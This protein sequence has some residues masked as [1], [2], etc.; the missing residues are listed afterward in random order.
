MGS[1]RVR[2]I[3]V[4]V[5]EVVAYVLLMVGAIIT[6]ASGVSGAVNSWEAEHGGETG[7][8]TP[9]EQHCSRHRVTTVVCTWNGTWVSDVD[10]RILRDVHLDDSL[11]SEEGDAPPEPVHPALHSDRFADP[12]MVYLPG[13]R[14]WLLAP[15]VSILLIG[16]QVVLAWRVHRWAGAKRVPGVAEKHGTGA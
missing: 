4:T 1:G 6:A 12:Q 16:I 11:G 3:G 14:T 5:V 15:A 9:V 8:F 2:R 10:G 13:E 7:T